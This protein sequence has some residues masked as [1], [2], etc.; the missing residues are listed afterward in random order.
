MIALRKLLLP[1]VFCCFLFT[2]VDA[3]RTYKAN[4]VLASGNWFKI[5]VADDGVYKMDVAFL[6]SLGITGS[7]PSAQVRIFGNGGGLLSENARNKPGDDIAEGALWVEDGGDGVLNGADYVLFYGQGPDHWIK[8]SATQRFVHQKNIYSGK[9]YYYVNIGGAGLRIASQTVSLPATATVNSFDERYFHEL[10]TVN[11]LSSGKEW[12]G[13]EFSSSPGRTLNKTFQ[14]PLS[15]LLPQ[16]ATLVTNIAARSVNVV[17]RFAVSANGVLVQQ[18]TVPPIGTGTY[19][20]FAQQVEQRDN[21]ILNASN[22]SISISYTQGSFNSQ[23]WLNWFEFFARRNLSVQG[24][25]QLLFRDWSSVGLGSVQF[26]V[27]DADAT[28]QVWDVTDSLHPVKMNGFISG[29]QLRFTNDA[30]RL[31]EYVCF[32]TN[33]LVPKA[34]GRVANQNLHSST[35][36]DLLIVTSPEFLQEAQRLAQFHQER[37]KLKTAVVTTEQVYNEF[38][39]GSPDP[40][41][42]RDF[43]KMYYDRYRSTWGQTGKYLLLF[44][45]ASFDYKNRITNNTN[46]VPAY[47]SA[48]SLDPLATYTSDDYFGFLNDDADINSSVIINQ[49]NIGVG[50]IPAR[51]PEEARNFVDKVYTYNSADAFGPWRN[52]LNFI[53]D[54]EDNNLHLQDAETLTATS[55]SVASVFNLQKIYLD[56]FHQES[57]SAG[58]R[59]PQANAVINSNIY[60][61]TLVWNYS[62]HG[63]PARLAEEDVLDQQIVNGWSNSNRLPLFITATCDFA[64][65]DN[66]IENSLGENLLVRPKTGAIG[67]MTTTRVVFAFSNRIINNNY[68]KFALEPDANGRYKT[69]GEALVASKNFTYQSSGDITNNRKFTLLGDPAMRLAFPTYKVEIIKV[70]DKD[71]SSQIDTLSAMEPGVVEGQVV[72]NSG[73]LLTNFNGT[74]YLSLFDKPLTIT[75]LGNDP[76]SPPAPFTDQE[77]TLFKGKASVQNGKFVFRFKVPKD[78]NYQYGN[79]KISLYAQDGTNDANGLSNSVIIGGISSTVSPDNQGPEIKAYLNDDKF[80]N[81]SIANANPILLLEMADSSGV[82]TGSSGI[83]HDIVATLDNNNS[84]YFVLNNFYEAGLDNFQKGTVRFQLPQLSAGHHTLKIK[85]WDVVNNSSEYV[86]EFTVVNSEDLRVDHVLNYPNPFTT[87]TFFWF[88]HNQPGTDLSVKVEIFT[89]SGKLIKTIS[90]TINTIGNRSNE[91]EW[92]GRDEYGEKIGRGVYIYRLRVKTPNGKTANKWERL[93]VLDK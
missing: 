91:I 25:K 34:E 45:K 4:S 53:A 64:P 86:L 55:S 14:L 38:S 75:T 80:V 87:R 82:N 41:A 57:G 59:Y 27:S 66:P 62:G 8:D 26:V 58:G 50:R 1:G 15:D 2:V 92:D 60:N 39:S 11:F 83:G 52:N 6:N 88:E 35:E 63:G 74:A 3:Q 89:V 76:T 68:L 54:D 16:P 42:I 22:A 81:G 78:I 73:A 70:N 43:A 90:Q 5:S 24:S 21:F 9:T 20:V 17:S 56:A 93:V 85:A 13:E 71:I 48:N 72:D 61:G 19:D 36:K 69:L 23:G 12:F 29:N 79:G 37:D 30:Q 47:E 18:V 33:F 44:G 65:Y 10:D 40:T 7:I 51:T 32:S 49:L 77:S 67:L 84:Q 28:S 31:R 46:K